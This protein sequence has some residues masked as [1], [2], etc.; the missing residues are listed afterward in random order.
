MKSQWKPSRFISAGV[1][2]V[3]LLAVGRNLPSLGPT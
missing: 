2:T 3:L 1:A